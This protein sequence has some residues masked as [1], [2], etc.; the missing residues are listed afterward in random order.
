[1]EHPDLTQQGP[2]VGQE[3]GFDQPG[4]PGTL[5]SQPAGRDLQ[6]AQGGQHPGGPPDRQVLTRPG[7]HRQRDRSRPVGHRRQHPGRSRPGDLRPTPAAAFH[8]LVFGDARSWWW[9]RRVEHLPASDPL[10]RGISQRASAVR[11]V[12]QLAAHDLIPIVHLTRRPRRTRLLAR[13]TT[14]RAAQTP[15]GFPFRVRGIR[16][17]RLGGVR[18]IPTHPGLQLN[19]LLGQGNQPDVLAQTAAHPAPPTADPARPKPRATPRHRHPTA[20]PGPAT[21]RGSHPTHPS[22]VASSAGEVTDRDSSARRA[23]KIHDHQPRPTGPADTPVMPP[24][25]EQLPAES[26]STGS[27]HGT[28]PITSSGLST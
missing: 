26:Y 10:G 12:L 25:P 28:L 21:E 1:M 18:R 5:G 27:E 24:E 23:A 9:W 16:R 8:Q 4:G 14:R 17:R 7:V 19:D 6:A 3:L 11:A 13:L 15:L 22:S 2:Y 20:P